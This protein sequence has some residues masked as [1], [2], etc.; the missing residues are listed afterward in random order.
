MVQFVL[1][2]GLVFNAGGG[3]NLGALSYTTGHWL[4]RLSE[5]PISLT[6]QF[7]GISNVVGQ[8]GTKSAVEAI[9]EQ[10]KNECLE[11]E[12]GNERDQCLVEVIDAVEEALVPF[13]KLGGEETDAGKGWAQ[14]FFQETQSDFFQYFENPNVYTTKQFGGRSFKG[15][16]TIAS[17]A[18][19]GWLFLAASIFTFLVGIIQTAMLIVAPI[20]A[21]L[22]FLPI[23]GD[24]LIHWTRNYLSLFLGKLVFNLL[25]TIAAYANL[26]PNATDPIFFPTVMALISISFSY[27]LLKGAGPELL[28]AGARTVAGTAFLAASAK[29]LF[30]KKS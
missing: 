15:I 24:S 28:A 26:K 4:S 30:R 17:I 7:L 29:H 3:S 1:I 19:L 23:F 5:V 12:R 22:S 2:M 10:G 20:L 16:S 13:M 14:R 6:S 18:I 9:R 27:G 25:A 8:A 21:G 11:L